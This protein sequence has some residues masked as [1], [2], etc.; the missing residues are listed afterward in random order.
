MTKRWSCTEVW[1]KDRLSVNLQFFGSAAD[2]N[3]SK[4][5]SVLT[6]TKTKKKDKDKDRKP[7][8]IQFRASPDHQTCFYLKSWHFELVFKRIVGEA[9]AVAC[10]VN[11]FWRRCIFSSPTRPMQPDC[12]II[13]L[14]DWISVTFVFQTFCKGWRT[15][16]PLSVK[17]IWQF[18][19]S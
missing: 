3:L 2:D 8:N 13:N 15:C 18:S 17:L 14:P 16:V 7:A 1:N 4:L 6:K 9:L 11:M 5:V 10:N 19:N 12:Q